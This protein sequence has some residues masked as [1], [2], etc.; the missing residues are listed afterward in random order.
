MG[1]CVENMKTLIQTL[2]FLL[3][4][5]ASYGTTAEVASLGL[6]GPLPVFS[7]DPKSLGS[8]SG[9]QRHR[10]AFAEKNLEKAQE[11]GAGW[12]IVTLRQWLDGPDGFERLDALIAM[13]EKYDQR[14]A[15]RLIEDPMVYA[16]LSEKMNPEFGYNRE[17]YEWIRSVLRKMPGVEFVMIG[18]EI[19]IN[20]SRP[21]KGYSKPI[22]FK[23][24]EY[25][26]Y[27]KMLKTARAAMHAEASTAKLVN[28]GFSDKTL[29]LAVAASI[30]EE[31]SLGEA[32]NLWSDWKSIGGKDAEGRIGLL[33]LLNDDE[34]EAKMR[35]LISSVRDPE[36]GIF[37]L[38]YYKYRKNKRP[39]GSR[40][41]R[42]S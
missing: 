30:Y 7:W 13:H 24:L 41:S 9:T 20:G 6:R 42:L 28:A 18:N 16:S 29:A 27:S 32:V 4:V 19:E 14:I 25:D 5:L 35:F 23:P 2:T 21:P 17:Y 11:L 39:N 8:M 22:K 40:S 37:Q 38:H 26:G 15:L 12:N 31:G 33:R 36:G 1:E 3:L 34:F 10:I